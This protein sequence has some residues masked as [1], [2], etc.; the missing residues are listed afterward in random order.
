MLSG[1]TQH[2]TALINGKK[3]TRCFSMLSLHCFLQAQK[4]YRVWSHFLSSEQSVKVNLPPWAL[5]SA[6]LLLSEQIPKRTGFCLYLLKGICEAPQ[7]NTVVVRSALSAMPTAVCEWAAGCV[8]LWEHRSCGLKLA[9]KLFTCFFTY[10][11]IFLLRVTW[12]CASRPVYVICKI[13]WRLL[14]WGF[15]SS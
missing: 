7:A 4:D 2:F 8:P 14:Q 5:R 10:L 11:L 12:A 9:E 3:G 6:L 15:S 1:F 13:L